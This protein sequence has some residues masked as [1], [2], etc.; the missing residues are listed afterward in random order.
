MSSAIEQALVSLV[1]SINTLPI[2][3]TTLANALLMQSRSKAANLKPEEEI[4][5]IYACAHIALQNRLG[6]DKLQPRPPVPPRVYKKLKTFF[7]KLLEVPSTPSTNRHIYALQRSGAASSR[8]ATPS[9]ARSAAKPTSRKRPLDTQ[10]D[11]PSKT[12]ATVNLPMDDIDDADTPSRRSEKR[13]RRP[14]STAIDGAVSSASRTQKRKSGN[15]FGIKQGEASVIPQWVDGMVA[16]LANRYSSTAASHIRAGADHVTTLRGYSANDPAQ[17]ASSTTK[18]RKIKKQDTPQHD[19][20]GVITPSRIP[21]LLIILTL[22]VVAKQKGWQLEDQ[23]EFN[24]KQSA[25]IEAVREMEEGWGPEEEAL[26]GDLRGFLSAAG[27]EGWLEADWFQKVTVG[28]EDDDDDAMDIDGGTPKPVK[29]PN[30]TPLRR[31]EKH[32]ARPVNSEDEEEEFA[33]GLQV[34]LG[35]MFQD[36][37][38]WLSDDRREEYREWKDGIM[39]K[40]DELE[41]APNSGKKARGSTI[42]R[43]VGSA[44]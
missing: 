29:R 8:K 12:P 7:E 11:T 1:P 34:G 44:A 23:E 20:S 39:H 14:P 18:S 38:D 30:K 27:E 24:E 10:D 9:S 2:E 33:A 41:G 43:R 16:R 40:L 25:G 35:T 36:A 28:E 26:M 6:V 21:A 5:R 13:A 22:F 4:G 19:G 31:K 3:L 15:L 32:A 37:V 17:S 42:G